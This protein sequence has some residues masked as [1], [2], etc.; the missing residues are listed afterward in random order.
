MKSKEEKINIGYSYLEDVEKEIQQN[1]TEFSVN[2]FSISPNDYYSKERFD[3]LKYNTGKEEKNHKLKK[4]ITIYDTEQRRKIIKEIEDKI[5]NNRILQVCGVSG[6]GKSYTLIDFV[7]KQR[8]KFLQQLKSNSEGTKFVPMY[9]YLN[10]TEENYFF[11][12]FKEELFYSIFPLI[13]D[14][15][16]QIK[17]DENLPIEENS[18][19]F[20]ILK[21]FNTNVINFMD[22][23]QNIFEKI[24]AII[25]E[26]YEVKLV[27]VIDQINEIKLNKRYNKMELIYNLL[28]KNSLNNL[29]LIQCASNNNYFSRDNYKDFLLSKTKSHFDLYYFNF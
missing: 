14:E 29:S 8:I 10:Q 9:F 6:M 3:F 23:I 18:L 25:N 2:L 15:Y 26:K 13:K 12:Y 22:S 27:V 5:K 17:S 28:L 4:Y 1:K 11:D 19:L 24:L 16:N 7:I 20:L 21:L